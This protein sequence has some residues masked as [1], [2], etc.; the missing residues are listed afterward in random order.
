MTELDEI[1]KRLAALPGRL[2]VRGPFTEEECNQPYG[3]AAHIIVEYE[4][5]GEFH[6]INISDID[7]NEKIL[8]S[9]VEFPTDIAKLI[10]AL[11]VACEALAVY[12]SESSYPE[13][14]RAALAKV[15]EVLK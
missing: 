10:T 4:E 8:N 14:A 6:T 5:D 3:E 15:K 13:D 12:S 7:D 2:F 11:E 1:K 9:L